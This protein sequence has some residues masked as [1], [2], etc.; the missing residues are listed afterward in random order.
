MLI[1]YLLQ[2]VPG[3]LPFFLNS[4]KCRT[5]GI[6]SNLGRVMEHAPVPRDPDGKIRL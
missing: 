3:L 6:L 2:K 4:S 1:M 5:T